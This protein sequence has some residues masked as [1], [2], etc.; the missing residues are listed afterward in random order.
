MA[1]WLEG[2]A[3]IVTGAGRGIGRAIAMLLAG[4]GAGVLVNDLGC[5]LGGHGTSSGPAD[6]VVEEIRKRG[7]NAVAD[8]ESVAT[9]AGAAKIAAHA[10]AAFDRIDIL[11]NNAGILAEDEGLVGM[12]EEDFDRQVDVNFKG[13]FWCIKAVL[14]AMRS[15]KYGRIVNISSGSALG[16]AQGESAYGATKAGVLGLTWCIAPEVKGDG[17]TVNSIMPTART[18]MQDFAQ[19]KIAEGK[20]KLSS[21]IGVNEPPEHIAPLVA[22]LAGES[23]G[24]ITGRTFSRRFI[25]TIGVMSE[26]AQVKSALKEGVWTIAEIDRVM[27]RLLP[28]AG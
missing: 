28:E 8:Y 12:S 13:A 23:A 3:A 19:A 5:D 11:V 7:G 14:P 10:M 1:R 22:Y 9:M 15:R 4:E 20:M 27:G 16:Y 6:S 17:I 2:R 26:P 25:N 21:E 18:R 24:R